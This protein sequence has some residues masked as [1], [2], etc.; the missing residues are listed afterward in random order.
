VIAARSTG[1]AATVAAL[2]LAAALFALGIRSVI[3][4]IGV[5][6]DARSFSE[7]LL[8][9]LHLTARIGL[10]FAFGGFL[11]GWALV[12]D[13]DR[14]GWYVLIPIALAGVQ[15][16]TSVLLSREPPSGDGQPPG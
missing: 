16:M 2:V 10:W 7:R 5:D 6:F 11:A 8:F 1:D 4:W 12:E 14:F 9:A 13:P 15:L 3:R